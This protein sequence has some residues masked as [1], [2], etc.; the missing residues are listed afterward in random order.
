MNHPPIATTERS[1]WLLLVAVA[2][3]Y[4]ALGVVLG[5]IQG[6]IAPILRTRG[7]Q[8]ASMGWVFALYIPFG[9]TFLWAPLVDRWSPAWLGRRTG[10]IVAAQGCAA[11]MVVGIAMGEHLPTPVLFA[12]GFLTALAMATM[13]VALDAWTVEQIAE[14]HRPMAAGAKVGGM[15]LGAILGGGVMVALFPQL[16]WT[17][18]FATIAG[19]MALVTLPV[20]L[21]AGYETVVRIS[22]RPA[23]SL[24]GRLKQPELR[25]RLLRIS[26]VTCALMAL[27][28]FNR[29]MLV[30]SGVS[31]QRIGWILGIG[32][33]LANLAAS[34][35]TPWLVRRWSSPHVLWLM[36]ACAVSSA[37]LIIV[38]L[39]GALPNLAIV[40]SILA[41]ASVT[42]IYVVMASLILGW[43]KGNQAATDYALLYGVGRFIGT[44]GLLVLPGLIAMVGWPLFYAACAVVVVCAVGHF[45]A[46]LKGMDQADHLIN[47]G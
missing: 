41:G 8:L 21:L 35:G 31:L 34:V 42:G 44:L 4:V 12:L 33:P 40:A 7:I 1:P 23:V 29:L 5:F 6:G 15:S 16:G 32:A 19:L 9:I 39:F 18:T 11:A 17:A 10:W 37:V 36:V 2:S 25:G 27:F 43:A 26:L 47:H 14:R 46:G 3:M 13:D 38:S 22:A 30:D 28:N 45:I 20:W 24:L